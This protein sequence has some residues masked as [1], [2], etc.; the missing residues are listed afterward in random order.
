MVEELSALIKPLTEKQKSWAKNKLFPHFARNTMCKGVLTC[1]DCGHTWN[2][3]ATKK[4]VC[5]CCG[6]KLEVLK[7]NRQR[8]VKERE[9]FSI[10]TTCKEYQV[11]RTFFVIF[12][13]HIGQPAT[14]EFYEVIQKWIDVEGNKTIRAM[15]TP[16]NTYYYDAWSLTSELS[17]KLID[18]YRVSASEVYPAKKV[19]PILKRNGFK[20][21]LHGIDPDKL[22]ISILKESMAETLFKAAQYNL[23]KFYIDRQGLVSRN[24]ASIKICIRNNYIVKDASLWL[25]YLSDLHYLKKDVRNAHYICSNNIIEDHNRTVQARKKKTEKEKSK[26]EA[27]QAELEEEGFKTTHSKFFNLEFKHN[28]TKITVLSSVEAYR[29]EAEAMHNC[30]F[31]RGYYKNKNSLVLSAKK[32]NK[33]I[34]TI[35]VNLKSLEIVQCRGNCNTI[36]KGYDKI[37]SIVNKNMNKIREIS[38]LQSR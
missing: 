8:T 10:I 3:E 28:K 31:D 20:N 26:A 1:F 22:F 19:I 35:E 27:I 2:G 25:D 9:Y 34:A 24:W 29:Q 15:T 4:T 5:P 7:S 38:L 23:L 18:N 12:N 14:Y 30:L 21:S 17:I 33:R 16:F 11:I 32:N 13:A 6:Q 36:P 37:L